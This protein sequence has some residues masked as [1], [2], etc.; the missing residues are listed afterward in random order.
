[1]CTIV[2]SYRK[3]FLVLG[4]VAALPLL[5]CLQEE[6]EVVPAALGVCVAPACPVPVPRGPVLFL[7]VSHYAYRHVDRK[8][9]SALVGLKPTASLRCLAPAV[10]R[11][12]HSAHQ[13]VHPCLPCRPA[14]PCPSCDCSLAAAAAASQ[15]RAA[16]LFSLRL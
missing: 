4:L 15:P 16:G 7:G 2:P 5:A 14:S 10:P 3:V 12:V 1:M 8:P 9:A 11:H 13:R 6:Q